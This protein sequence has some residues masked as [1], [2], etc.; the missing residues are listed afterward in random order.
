MNDLGPGVLE[1]AFVAAFAGG[2][3]SLLAPCSALLLPAFFA[4]AFTS[5][6]ELLGRTL[7]FL[8]GL[9]TIFIPLGLGAS[10]VAALLLDYREQTI[11]AAGLLL[12]GF[13]TLEITG[14]G[15]SF[16]PRRLAGRVQA[17][18][19][20]LSVYLTGLVYGVSGFCAGPLLGAVLTIAGSTASPLTGAALLATYSIGTATPLFVIAWLWDRFQLGRRAWLRGR[21]VSIGPLT[22]HTTNLAAGT[23]FILLGLSFIQ[24]QGASVLS[25]A[26]ATL[27][28]EEAGYDAQ[29]WIA[30]QGATLI[31]IVWLITGG[32]GLLAFWRAIRWLQQWGRLTLNRQL[33]FRAYDSSARALGHPE[34]EAR[35]EAS[36]SRA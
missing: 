33:S 12:I 7:L 30:S 21:I 5:K 6:S 29:A 4:Y 34:D 2:V 13:G 26:Y 22:T 31:P 25:G 1:A 11:L 23:V 8:A 9:C 16:I 35:M 27:G 14:T 20:L 24:L 36:D 10:L 32:L 18:R 17:G 19:G 28:L 3:L 15:F